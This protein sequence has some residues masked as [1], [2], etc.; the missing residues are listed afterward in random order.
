MLTRY[1]SHHGVYLRPSLL[2]GVVLVTRLKVKCKLTILVENT[3]GMLEEF[4]ITDGTVFAGKKSFGSLVCHDRNL[5][6]V[7]GRCTKAPP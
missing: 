4:V 6:L 7:L 3:M 5:Y 2:C 1:L